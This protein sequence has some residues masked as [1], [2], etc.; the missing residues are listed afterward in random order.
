MLFNPLHI[1]YVQ[2]IITIIIVIV[3]DAVPSLRDGGMLA[4]HNSR[5]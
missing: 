4:Q 3:P 1:I 2:S 5:K